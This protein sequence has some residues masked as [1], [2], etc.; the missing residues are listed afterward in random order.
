MTKNIYSNV[1]INVTMT[2]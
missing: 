1:H 2:Q